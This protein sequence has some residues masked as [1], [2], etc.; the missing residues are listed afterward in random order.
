MIGDGDCGEI[1]G[2]KIGRGNRSTR[3]KLTQV[4]Y[5]CFSSV[6]TFRFTSTSDGTGEI[7]VTD[8]EVAFVYFT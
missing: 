7:Y 3:R 4:Q 2:M 8:I 6:S 5:D 1:G